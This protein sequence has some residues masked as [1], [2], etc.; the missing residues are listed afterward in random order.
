M[1]ILFLDRKNIEIRTGGGVLTVYRDGARRNA[2]PLKMLDRIIIRAD[3][4]LSASVLTE[5]AM[6]GVALTLITGRRGEKVAHLVGP[7]H[8]DANRRLAQYRACNDATQRFSLAQ[9]TV[10]AKVR[11]QQG[12][13]ETLIAARPDQHRPLTKSAATLEGINQKIAAESNIDRLRGLEGA[14]AS[15]SFDALKAVLPDSLD[16]NGRNRRPPRDPVNACLSLAYTLAHGDAI[17]ACHGAG[18]DPYLGF[19][20]DNAYGRESLASDLIEPLRPHIDEWVWG[21]F[22]DRILNAD[23]FSADGQACLLQKA[24]RQHFYAHWSQRA[25]G[26]KRYLRRAA[27][28]LVKQLTQQP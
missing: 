1:S 14:A 18:L 11:N 25:P 13:I 12:F 20:H 28:N 9:A 17:H 16:F 8:N 5:L 10:A 23:H 4:A 27:Y 2:V 3:V 15:A 21:L 24:G 19:L 26:F 6:Q 7:Q 22:R